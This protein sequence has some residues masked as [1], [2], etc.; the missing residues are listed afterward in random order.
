L[1]L[2]DP[3]LDR[4]GGRKSPGGAK[5]QS[6]LWGSGTKPPEAE[7]TLQIVHVGK[8]YSQKVDIDTVVLQKSVKK[9]RPKSTNIFR[10]YQSS[11]IKARSHNTT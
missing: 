1:E 10:V 2:G 6:P 9:R 11:T 3:I 4:F 7:E 8:V 5:G